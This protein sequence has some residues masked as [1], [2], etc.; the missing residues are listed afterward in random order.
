MDQILRLNEFFV[1]GGKQNISHV[2]LHITEPSTPEE[3]KK[4]YFFALCEMNG[5]IADDISRLQGLI[6]RAENEYYEMETP[7]GKDPFETVL[8]NANKSAVGLDLPEDDLH[9]IVGAIREKEII[10]SFFG[11]PHL[12]LFYK[13]KSG[14][15]EQMDLVKSNNDEKGPELFS[16][17]VQGKL[18]LGDYL[19]AGTP[20]IIDFF[21]HDRLLKII[22]T[23]SALQSAKHLEKVLGE[24]KNGYSFG[25]LVINLLQ[26][27]AE[28][29]ASVKK[30]R[31]VEHGAST[32]S[33]Q[34][35]FQREQSTADT[36][37]PSLLPKLNK[38]KNILNE[39]SNEPVQISRQPSF[40][41]SEKIEAE[42]NAAHLA[43]RPKRPAPAKNFEDHFK[44]IT[45]KI[46]LG[47]KLI[48][49]LLWAVV[50]VVY[51]FFVQ[52]AR[53]IGLLAI[54]IF[55]FKN[56]R[57]TV[58]ES[59]KGW[60]RG[61]KENYR[62][63]PLPTKMMLISSILLAVG[64]GASVIY[65]KQHQKAAAFEQSFAAAVSDLKNKANDIESKMIISDDA[66]ANQLYQDA[67][68]KLAGL[69]C[70]VKNH[71]TECNE[72]SQRFDQLQIKLKKITMV[73]AAEL[74]SVNLP[75]DV[76][77]IGIKNKI[78]GYSLA[79]STLFVYDL[80]SR[81][82]R[83]V[84]GFATIPGFAEAAVPKENDYAIFL[85]SDNKLAQLDPSSLTIK[86]I[87]VSYP[88]EGASVG[89]M[90][91]YNRRLYTV[92]TYNQTIYRHD[93]IKTGFGRGKAWLKDTDSSLKS[94]VNMAVDGDLYISRSDG[95][96]SRFS[97]GNPSQYSI[98]NLNPK[99]SYNVYIWTYAEVPN[100]YILEPAQ[101]RL[102]ITDKDG[103][104]V[105]QLM[106]D[107]LTN[108]TGFIIDST[109][110]TAFIADSGK[111][112]KVTLPL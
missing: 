35:L 23:R 78:V 96:I 88:T 26:Q 20:H 81:D 112:M 109:S 74:A 85:Y 71:Q 12:L 95:G 30:V 19:F 59:W 61:T 18:S 58:I 93:A 84:P 63:L 52:I 29:T 48:G 80:N 21:S 94:S 46:W 68:T 2:L 83:Y 42:I 53:G 9:C 44:N 76:K 34:N 43:Q 47:L 3:T 7:E 11:K 14:N 17:V 41:H 70:D 31:A 55:N 27:E 79:T 25:G 75:G 110:K 6:D 101:K 82:S 8:E 56:R 89:A 5:A 111:L 73:E 4:G 15:Y 39:E 62:H 22:T 77:L 54:I 72:L 50:A 40:T 98:T 60:W 90:T 108:P 32:K 104:V 103:N 107:S 87:D 33:L 64:F 24:L 51:M 10:F 102:V 106:S 38:I 37:S 28:Q 1:E 57:A 105:A 49:R 45:G 99:L 66:G 69:S 91:I 16:Q 65:I 100:L 67:E 86:L 92:D 36:L 13:N 97:G